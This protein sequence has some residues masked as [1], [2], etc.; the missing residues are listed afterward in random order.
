MVVYVYA[1]PVM[2]LLSETAIDC[3][4]LSE[5]AIDSSTADW[6]SLSSV[7][8]LSLQCQ[9]ALFPLADVDISIFDVFPRR[10]HTAVGVVS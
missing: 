4:T 7:A 5:T 1:S 2:V 10:Y 6:Q 3:Y 9:S 8:F